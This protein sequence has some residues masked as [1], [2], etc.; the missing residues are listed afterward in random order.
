MVEYLL[1]LINTCEIH[2]I[3]S[4]FSLLTHEFIS[5]AS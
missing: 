2:S 5:I 4:I 1:I 3:A